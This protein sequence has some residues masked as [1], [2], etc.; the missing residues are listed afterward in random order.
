VVVVMMM[1]MMMMMM[2]TMMI[3]IVLG[4]LFT[5]VVLCYDHIEPDEKVENIH[6]N[7]VR[8]HKPYNFL[9]K[10]FI[11]KNSSRLNYFCLRTH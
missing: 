5:D 11:I 8:E 7:S 4:M 9:D 2:M 6:I 1:M 3:I 10:L